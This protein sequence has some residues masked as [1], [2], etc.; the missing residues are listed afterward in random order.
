MSEL[1]DCKT[2]DEIEVFLAQSGDYRFTA[3]RVAALEHAQSLAKKELR[4][5]IVKWL[6]SN[7][8]PGYAVEI[9]Y[10]K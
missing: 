5:K 9:R 2:I 10:L 7:G 1:K 4:D 6:E 3:E 8:Q